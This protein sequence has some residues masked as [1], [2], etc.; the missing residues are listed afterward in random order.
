MLMKGSLASFVTTYMVGWIF[1]FAFIARNFWH[2]IFSATGNLSSL[3]HVLEER[4]ASLLMEAE[5]CSL[6]DY[7][8]TQ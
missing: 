2:I 7:V 4:N 1:D 8:Q 5:D 3:F 6:L